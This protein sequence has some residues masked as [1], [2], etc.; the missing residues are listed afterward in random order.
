MKKTNNKELQAS[1]YKDLGWA[2]LMQNKLN[3]AQN[4]LE[5]ATK[6]DSERTDAY[7]LLSQIEESLGQL[8]YARAYIDACILTKS[9]LPEVFFWREQLLNRILDK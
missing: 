1:L 3:E 8:N 2:K 5:K 4:Y 6:L 9:S 7:C